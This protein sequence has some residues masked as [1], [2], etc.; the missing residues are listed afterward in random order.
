ALVRDNFRCMVTGKVDFKAYM[1]GLALPVS[2]EHVTTTRCCHIF[3]DS[4]GHI[5]ELLKESEAASVWAILTRLGYEDI[6]AELRSALEEANL[7]RLSNIL[8]L[9]SFIHDL[10]DGLSLW[11]EAVNDKPNF[12]NI[13]LAP[14]VDRQLMSV[15]NSVQFVSRHPDLPLPNT[16]YLHINSTC[17][18]VAHLSGA[19]DYIGR[20]ASEAEEAEVLAKDGASADVLAFALNRHLARAV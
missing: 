1:K 5:T 19:V 17:C 16:R 3:P 20:I 14:G 15:P 13:A 9:A 4:L 2:G 12:Y 7:Y 10:F 18:R 11:F 6:R 8:M